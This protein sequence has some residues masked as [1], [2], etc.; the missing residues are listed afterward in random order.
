MEKLIKEDYIHGGTQKDFY[1]E[2]EREFCNCPLCNGN[3]Y[4]ELDSERGWSIVRCNQCDLIYTN[5]RA[6]N[7]EKNYFC[8]TTTANTSL[9]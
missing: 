9:A 7:A 8:D 3:N 2:H 5:P 1:Q 6:K 4:K